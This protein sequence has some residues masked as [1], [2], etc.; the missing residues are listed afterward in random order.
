MA[1]ILAAILIRI[2]R[3]FGWGSGSGLFLVSKLLLIALS[4]GN[5]LLASRNIIA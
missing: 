4:N 3:I 2:V 5:N 1:S